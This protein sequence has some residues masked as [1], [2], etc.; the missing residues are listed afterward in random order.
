MNE[1]LYNAQI[2]AG[3]VTSDDVSHPKVLHFGDS[4]AE[5]AAAHESAAVFDLSDRTQLEVTGA[6]RAT[7]L[8]NFC[9]NEIKGLTA[10]QGCEAFLVNVKARVLGHGH[11]AVQDE[12]ICFHSAAGQQSALL[13][14]LSKYIITE[15]VELHD[16]SS[17]WS[18][19]LISGQASV[20]R[21]LDLGADVDELPQNGMASV[22]IAAHEIRVQRIDWLGAPGFFLTVPSDGATDIWHACTAIG[23]VPAGRHAFDARRIEAGYPLFGIDMNDDFL[24]PEIG[25]NEQAISY[26]KGC[27]L[28]QEPIARMD[29]MGHVNRELRVLQIASTGSVPIGSDVLHNEKSVGRVSSV[30]A[31]PGTNRQVALAVIRTSAGTA[32]TQLSVNGQTASVGER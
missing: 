13:E 22:S 2:S 4:A 20:A 11:F 32:G 27:Y 15:D 25:R 12:S 9:T 1:S 8:H 29:A 5:Y 23:I 28:G 21:L 10:G 31:V 7:Y 14:H 26:N 24:A 18:G 16:R 19:V 30:A 17:E 3:A 6:D